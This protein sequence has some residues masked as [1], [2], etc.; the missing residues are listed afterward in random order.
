MMFNELEQFVKNIKDLPV[1]TSVGLVGDFVTGVTL[2]GKIQT[3]AVLSNGV[4]PPVRALRQKKAMD[5]RK[6]RRK[7]VVAREEIEVIARAAEETNSGE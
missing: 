2:D 5:G 4:P 3:V 6:T 1:L 7:N